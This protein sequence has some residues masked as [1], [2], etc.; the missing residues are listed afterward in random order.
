[1]PRYDNEALSRPQRVP[2]R[3]RLATASSRVVLLL[4]GWPLAFL[5]QYIKWARTACSPLLSDDAQQLLSGYY[6]LRRQHEA[7]QGSRTTVRMLESLVRVAQ[8]HA[9]LM[10]RPQVRAAW[11]EGLCVRCRTGCSL[12]SVNCISSGTGTWG[13]FVPMSTAAW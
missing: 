4:Q 3:Q 11:F 5:R 6:Q 9:R 10:A 8:A 1:M 2:Q 7:R 12:H 13:R